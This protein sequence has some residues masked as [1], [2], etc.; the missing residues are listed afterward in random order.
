MIVELIHPPH[1]SA[2]DDKLDAPLGL[3]YIASNLK[4]HGHDV[5]V[6]D[7]SG[8]KRDKDK[9]R[10]M[11]SGADLYGVTD[12]VCTMDISKE[13]ADICREKNPE[14]R[15]IVGG[16]NV[17]GFV[18]QYSLAYFPD[19]FDSIVVGDGEDPI[20]EVIK[21]FPNLAQYYDFPLD[22]DLDIYP[23]PDY[24]MI[25]V[26]SYHRKIDDKKSISIL[27][28]RGC[29]F[30]CSFCGLPKQKRTVR[31]RSSRAQPRR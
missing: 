5:R 29:P 16:A 21:D 22:R 4:K 14:C 8:T 9:W 19:G 24:E 6:V 31:Y 1:P 20:L 25:D 26:H 3:L 18:E 15:V 28:S 30:R 17:T 7:L 13:I 27:T 12:Y 10:E 23:N 2:T 11:I